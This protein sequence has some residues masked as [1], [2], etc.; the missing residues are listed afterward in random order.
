M[1]PTYYGIRI[2]IRDGGY[3]SLITTNESKGDTE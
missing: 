1:A 2:G 3:R